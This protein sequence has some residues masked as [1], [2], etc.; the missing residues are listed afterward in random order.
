MAKSK[1][2]TKGEGVPGKQPQRNR[3]FKAPSKGPEDHIF[4]FRKLLDSAKSNVITEHLNKKAGSGLFNKDGPDAAFCIRILKNPENMKPKCP[5]PTMA[6]VTASGMTPEMETV[7]D[8][9]N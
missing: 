6:T 4:H 8:L 1:N 2:P 9:F 7:Y 3:W 5:T